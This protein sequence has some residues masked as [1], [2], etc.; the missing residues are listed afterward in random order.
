MAQKRRA[1]NKKNQCL[2]LNCIQ[3]EKL[4]GKYWRP[5]M[6]A[7]LNI[8]RMEAKNQIRTLPA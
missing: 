5:S 4:G 2:V 8:L 7:I 1:R 3:F 6:K